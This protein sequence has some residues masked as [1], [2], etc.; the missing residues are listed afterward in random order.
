MES[1]NQM[2]TLLEKQTIYLPHSR[3]VGWELDKSSVCANE[4][5]PQTVNGPVVVRLTTTASLVQSAQKTAVL[6]LRTFVPST[7]L[8]GTQSRTQKTA[9]FST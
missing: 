4:N 9:R 3:G 2:L 5:E 8:P 6:W 1:S 7:Y